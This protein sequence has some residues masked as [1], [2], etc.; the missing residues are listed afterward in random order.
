MLKVENLE[1]GYG[2]MQVLWKPNLEVKEGTI[3]ALL[4]P[5][6]VGKTTALNTILGAVKP[7]SGRIF[8]EG[9]DVTYIKTHRKVDMGVVLVPEGKHLFANMSTYENLI[10]G[11]YSKRASR[12]VDES[13]DLVYT[14]FPVLK[15]RAGQKSGSLSGGEQQMVTIG[16][17]WVT[18]PKLIKCDAIGRAVALNV[19]CEFCD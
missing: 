12:H 8:Y 13:L 6:G 17:A 10:V 18:G 19:V 14:M 7:W 3:T 11:A 15:E 9:E 2:A 4:G 1:S 5:N 16:R